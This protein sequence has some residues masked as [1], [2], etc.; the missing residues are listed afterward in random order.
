MSRNGERIQRDIQKHKSGDRSDGGR[1]I[2]YY[3]VGP[4]GGWEQLADK[5]ARDFRRSLEFI[6]RVKPYTESDLMRKDFLT[7]FDILQEA[8]EE[9][10]RAIERMEKQNNENAK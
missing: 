5:V 2:G 3:F 7:Y 1:I 10:R 8:E 9:E 6:M 4:S